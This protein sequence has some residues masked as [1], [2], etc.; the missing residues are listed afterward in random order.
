[1]TKKLVDSVAVD[2][3]AADIAQASLDATAHAATV[4]RGEILQAIA[5]LEASVT[6]RRKREALLTDAGKAWL[7]NVDALI[8]AE[9]AKL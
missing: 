7:A 6:E 1:M 9:R 5:R 4:S 3:S 2:L 8:A